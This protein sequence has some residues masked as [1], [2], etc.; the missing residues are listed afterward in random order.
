MRRNTVRYYDAD[1]NVHKIE[2]CYEFHQYSI[3][4]DDKFYAAADDRIE[5]D[6]A[7]K[8]L[9]EYKGY[10]VKRPKRAKKKTSPSATTL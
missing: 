6:D 8:A 4:H 5:L 10:T 9:V 7:V 3:Y 2:T 1:G